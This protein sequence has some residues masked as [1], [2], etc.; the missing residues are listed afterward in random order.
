MLVGEQTFRATDR[1]IEYREV[2][3][4]DAKGKAEP[5]PAWLAVAPRARFGVDLSGPGVH[6][7]SGARRSWTGS[8][9]PSQRVP[10]RAQRRTS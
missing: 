3:P 7:S 1:V 5:V 10:G 2:E 4:V 9:A 6:R 8:R